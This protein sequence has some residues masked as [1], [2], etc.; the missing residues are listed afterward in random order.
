MIKLHVAVFEMR[1]KAAYPLLL[2]KKYHLLCQRAKTV[3]DQQRICFEVYKYVIHKKHKFQHVDIAVD[4]RSWN[5]NVPN[6]LLGQ[7][8]PTGVYTAAPELWRDI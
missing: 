6:R 4:L 5:G 8:A 1:E 3:V 7:G 2:A